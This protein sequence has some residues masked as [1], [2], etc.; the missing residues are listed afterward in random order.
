MTQNNSKS[1][2]WIVVAIVVVVLVVWVARNWDLGGSFKLDRVHP[3][4]YVKG[5]ASSTAIVIEYGDFQCPACRSYYLAMKQLHIEFGDEVAF[6]YRHFPLRK[7]YS[8][9]EMAARAAEAARKQDKFWEM[10]DLLFEKQ[11]EWSN[12]PDPIPLFKSYAKLLGIS[13]EQFDADLVSYNT[14]NFVK[15]QEINATRLKLQGTPT[16]FINGEQI[17]NPSSVEEFKALIRGT[18]TDRL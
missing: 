5:N 4:D 3:Q 9:A 15:A 2:I 16:F 11:A 12:V 18:I 13:L 8:N 14:K 7:I 1:F 10:H 17:E 6:V